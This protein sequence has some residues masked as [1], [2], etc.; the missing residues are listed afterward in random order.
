MKALT[1]DRL[2]PGH[3]RLRLLAA[4]AAGPRLLSATLVVAFGTIS[5]SVAGSTGSVTTPAFAASP[6]VAWTASS[7]PLPAGAGSDPLVSLSSVAC[8]V[9]GSCV[10]TGN[11]TD[12][13]GDQQGLIETLSGGTWTALSA[14]LPAG[15]GTEPLV[16]L[17]SVT[18]PADGS[19][20]ATGDYSD[21]SGDQLGLIE[22]LS[23]G[24][25][26]ALLAPLPAGAGGN[27]R[28]TLNAPACPVDGSCVVTGDYADT[29]ASVR[30]TIDTLAGG[31][32]T[33][34]AAP[35][36]PGAVPGSSIGAPACP[37]DGTC[38]AMAEY[39][40]ISGNVQ[41]AI[42][43][44]SGGTWSPLE[45]PIPDGDAASG[46][47]RNILTGVNCA[48]PGSCV[49]V[50]SFTPASGNFQGLIETLSGGSWTPS[51]AQLPAGAPTTDG[52]AQL[53]GVTCP[54]TGA[55]V[56]I[57]W[58]Y[59]TSGNYHVVME[60]QSGGV[61]TPMAQTLPR[62][63]A[64]RNPA[65]PG[66]GIGNASCAATG[67]CVAVG[68]YFEK[69]HKDKAIIEALA[70]GNWSTIKAPL[71]TNAKGNPAS[72][73]Q[74]VTCSTDGS[75]MAVGAVGGDP[76]IEALPGG[77]TSPSVSSPNQVTF[78]VD[79]PG[80]FIVAA[81]GTPVPSITKKGK[82]P[83]GLHFTAGTGTATISG[84]PLGVAGS[85]SVTIEAQNGV[86]PTASQFLTVTITS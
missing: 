50:G 53:D 21:T 69:G 73:L 15:A 12:T 4:I 26:T 49:A 85:F 42:E 8:P 83:K 31:V 86:L 77:E 11:Y 28:S 41:T 67:S 64:A 70:G 3:S 13:S 52:V 2:R 65:T 27:P 39:T 56:A 63:P 48:T 20:V 60:T 68:S 82:L 54:A 7:A 57:G 72:D 18:C 74:E 36:P 6:V 44:L 40:D 17:G 58:Y 78:T 75:C 16:S 1:S 33:A 55:C 29:S 81:T 37:A 19:C 61:W 32:W 71:P 84:T 62:S 45:A 25:W 9:D 59:D 22:T 30:S 43:T 47:Q 51:A 66:Q 14:P 23:G 5:M 80:S 10:A 46:H 76:L 79:T 24:V 38:E 35:L 34:I